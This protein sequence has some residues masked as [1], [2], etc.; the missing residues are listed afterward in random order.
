M[1]DLTF[2]ITHN[3]RGGVVTTETISL[4][5]TFISSLADSKIESNDGIPA[6]RWKKKEK[7]KNVMGAK[8][9]QRFWEA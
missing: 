9:Q 2:Y 4:L 3:S 7:I 8:T 6:V 1:R 5:A